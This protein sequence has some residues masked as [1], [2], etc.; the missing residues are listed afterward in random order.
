[1]ADTAEQ[2]GYGDT[3]LIDDGASSAYVVIDNVIDFDP[4]DEQLGIVVG[5]YLTMTNRRLT[6]TPTVFDPGQARIKQHMSQV[7][8][9]RME[10]L[11][12]NRTKKNFKYVMLDNVSN[13]T[14]IVAGYVR[15][16][17]HGPVV[18]DEIKTFESQIEHTGE[19]T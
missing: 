4:P 15:S 13:T 11:K 19:Q 17:K 3:I 6:K 8:Y 7:G 1:M 10:G 2:I 16:N 14:V 9:S 5:K 18:A 12:K